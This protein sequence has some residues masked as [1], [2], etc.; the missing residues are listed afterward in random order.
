MA[1]CHTARLP[2]ECNSSGSRAA[3]LGTDFKQLT[4][5]R[6]ISLDLNQECPTGSLIFCAMIDKE[7]RQP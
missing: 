7:L 2:R 4:L 6:I 5:W 1:Q 3:A